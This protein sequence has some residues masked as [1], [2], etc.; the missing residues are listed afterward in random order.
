MVEP[1]SQPAASP[2]EAAPSRGRCQQGFRP[3]SREID[4]DYRHRKAP[5]GMR[6]S[7]GSVSGVASR[8]Q[9]GPRLVPSVVAVDDGFSAVDKRPRDAI[10]V[11]DEPLAVAREVVAGTRRAGSDPL[12][13]EDDDV[14]AVTN[15]NPTSISQPEQA[16]RRIG[17]QLDRALQGH[18]L[19]TSQ[20]IREE[21]TGGRHYRQIRA[22]PIG[23]MLDVATEVLGTQF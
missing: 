10:R 7:A 11:G 9:D 19:S 23:A 14:G 17:H 22:P 20:S 4:D 15:R 1:A 3:H 13:I 5:R 16:R 12:G 2:E 18:Q 8:P 6:D 21:P